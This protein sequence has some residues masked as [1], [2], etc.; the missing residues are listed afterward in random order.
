MAKLIGPAPTLVAHRGF[1]GH[2]PENTLLA[3]QEAH[4]CGA[5]YMELDLQLTVDH[6]PVLHHDATLERM[7]GVE[8]DVRDITAKRF[9]SL[10]AGYAERFDDRFSD[11]RFTTLKKFCKW[12]KKN[13][14]LIIFLE[15]KQESID[16]FG[17]PLFIDEVHQRILRTKVESQCVMISFNHEAL[18]YTRQVST[19]PV[20]WVLPEWSQENHK[21]ALSSRPDFLFCDTQQLPETDQE[22]WQGSW[23]WAVYNL[24]DVESAIAMANRGI[25]FLE[26]NQIGALMR[27]ASLR[28]D[29]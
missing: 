29:N 27:D 11:N 13:P 28:G 15:I 5:K 19:L 23:Q 20:G 24:D 25:P 22:I 10:S 14:D 6:V 16:R 21:L 3:Y 8:L 7:A 2:Y 12:L 4:R 9:K 26:T 18:V 17:I 1:S